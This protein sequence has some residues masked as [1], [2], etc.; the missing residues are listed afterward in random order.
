MDLLDELRKEGVDTLLEDFLEILH[1][2]LIV[3]I[4]TELLLDF[5]HL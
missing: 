2:L 4:K 1:S 5:H 3:Q